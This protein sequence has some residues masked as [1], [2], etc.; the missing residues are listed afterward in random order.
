MFEKT[1]KTAK[2]VYSSFKMIL[3]I[4]ATVSILILYNPSGYSYF[5]L[6]KGRT[7]EFTP[8]YLLLYILPGI[9]LLTA[10][11]L[12]LPAAW[13]A[14]GTKGKLAFLLIFLFTGALLVS[15]GAYKKLTNIIWFL[16]LSL[17]AFIVFGAYVRY[18][19]RKKFHTYGT[20]EVGAVDVEDD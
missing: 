5:H 17:I 13:K 3:S 19:D 16:E 11:I 6:L 12:D 10:I 8:T 2:T 18:R 15:M 1:T 9:L 14:S 20:D 7:F 4:V